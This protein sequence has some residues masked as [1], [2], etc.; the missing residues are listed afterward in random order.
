M[1]MPAFGTRPLSR[2]SPARFFDTPPLSGSTLVSACAVH[3]TH[4]RWFLW[5]HLW[6]LNWQKEFQCTSTLPNLPLNDP[7]FSSLLL[8]I[9]PPRTSCA[10]KQELCASSLTRGKLCLPCHNVLTSNIELSVFVWTYFYVL[11]QG[12]DV[13]VIRIRNTYAAP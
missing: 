6:Q 10:N 1:T 8:S 9:S 12:Y 5:Q 7:S 13:Y 11:T 3:T 2:P 4:W